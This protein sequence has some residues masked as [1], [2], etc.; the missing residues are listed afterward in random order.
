[1]AGARRDRVVA[2][3]PNRYVGS[4]AEDTRTPPGD[5]FG[6]DGLAADLPVPPG[7]LLQPQHRL[8]VGQEVFE[9]GA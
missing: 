3:T 8:G 9:F 7:P 4:V 1:M 2:G 5:R 6:R